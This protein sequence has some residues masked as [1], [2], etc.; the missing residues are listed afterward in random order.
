MG[1]WLIDDFSDASTYAAWRAYDDG[2]GGTMMPTPGGSFSPEPST[3]GS[4]QALHLMGNGYTSWGA[5]IGRA[6]D[7][8]HEC[9]GRS[10][11]IRFRAK[12]NG[13]IT[14]AAPVAQVVPPSDGGTCT[15]GDGCHNSH[16]T[17]LSLNGTWTTYEVKWSELT[18][19]WGTP[20][21]FESTE[22]LEI[23]FAARLDTMP[24][25]YW[26]DDI[27]LIDD[28]SPVDPVNPGTGG[29]NAGTGGSDGTGGSTSG[30]DCV[31][32]EYL[33]ESGFNQWFN[34]RRDPFYTYAKLCE[35]LEDFPGFA[36]SGSAD[37]NKREIAA[38]FANVSRETGELDYIEQ[39]PES[40]GNTGNYYGRGPLQL[41][42][43]YNYQAAGS[44]LGVNLLANPSLLHTDGVLTWKAS[45]WF[46]MHADGAG[47]GTCHGAITG[48]AGFG[49]T[50]NV[51]N[52][53]LECPSS[54]NA[55]ALQR[56]NYYEDYC[57][58]L[59]VSPGGGLHC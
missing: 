27:E 48:S 23:L 19:G 28:G 3:D 22:V 26:I 2:S 29:S 40:R 37:A 49:Q 34:T 57:S 6:F 17:S 51:I 58:R 16:E 15:L 30:G 42:W 5:G 8:P 14:I 55:A 46:W 18:Q 21:A 20:V 50:I 25:D 54:G 32:D 1:D 4:G 38:F 41:T 39:F 59:G 44:F 7:V 53:G 52:G 56:I 31:L 36:N 10:I 47:K 24:F 12:G 35:A 13:T 43:D 11:G 9:Q 33:G 45:L